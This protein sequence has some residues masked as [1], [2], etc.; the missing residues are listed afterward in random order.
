[1][2]GVD[3][4]KKKIVHNGQQHCHQ[5]QIPVLGFTFYIYVPYEGFQQPMGVLVGQHNQ[6]G[7]T[8]EEVR[9]ETQDENLARSGVVF[10]SLVLIGCYFLQATQIKLKDDIKYALTIYKVL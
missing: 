4:K 3:A 8:E 2:L 9:M 7:G 6:A 10:W 1:M 5:S